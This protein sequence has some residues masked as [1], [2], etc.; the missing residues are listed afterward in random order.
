MALRKQGQLLK[1][2]WDSVQA[3]AVELSPKPPTPQTPE[4]AWQA[5]QR[6]TRRLHS[7][8]ATTLMIASAAAPISCTRHKETVTPHSPAS[9]ASQLTLPGITAQP[10]CA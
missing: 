5:V 7:A 2:T 9:P 3:A 10:I 1:L 4:P 8:A 6:R